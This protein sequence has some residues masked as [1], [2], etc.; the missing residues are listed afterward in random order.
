M[1]S[2]HVH[3][4]FTENPESIDAEMSRLRPTGSTNIFGVEV[5]TGGKIFFDEPDDAAKLF[6]QLS[7]TIVQAQSYHIAYVPTLRPGSA[8]VHRINIRIRNGECRGQLP[9]WQP[10]Q[11]IGN[12]PILTT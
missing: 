2:L 12:G 3:Q 11:V 10:V 8:A 9:S 4:Q 7:G 1:C 6:T 5:A